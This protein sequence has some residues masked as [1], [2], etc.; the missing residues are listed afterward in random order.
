MKN[1]N[2]FR[3]VDMDSDFM[4]DL[5]VNRVTQDILTLSNDKSKK[6]PEDEN[7]N[8]DVILGGVAFLGW[9]MTPSEHRVFKETV[10]KNLKENY[11]NVYRS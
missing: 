4:D 3:M 7:F 8:L 9:L 5:I 1:T 11:K 10:E 2:L 6:Y